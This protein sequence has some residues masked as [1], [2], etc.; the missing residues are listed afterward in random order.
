MNAAKM[1]EI[2]KEIPAE[3]F[4]MMVE[5]K[6]VD[7]I[8]SADKKEYSSIRYRCTSAP[9]VTDRDQLCAVKF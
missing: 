4:K 5:E 1:I 7:V 6:N 9:M 2:F 8:E 3:K